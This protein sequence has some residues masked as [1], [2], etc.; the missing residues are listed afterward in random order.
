MW[1]DIWNGLLHAGAYV[2]LGGGILIF[3]SLIHDIRMPEK[4]GHKGTML[5]NG[6]INA[7]V[8]TVSHLIASGF[9]TVA[10]IWTTAEELGTGIVATAV[11]GLVGVLVLVV[12][13]MIVDKLTPGKLTD[14]LCHEK[15]QPIAAVTAAANV[16]MG[17][18]VAVSIL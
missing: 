7:V 1:L 8:V 15:F 3:G 5:I 11:F 2:L 12:T 10:A 4:I 9:I 14:I 16:M 6:N 18:I 17:V 13:E